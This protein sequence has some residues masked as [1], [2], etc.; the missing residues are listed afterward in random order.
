MRYEQE[1]L[2]DIVEK[3]AE[4][5]EQQ[6][7]EEKDVDLTSHQHERALKGAYRSF[8]MPGKPKTDVDSYFDQAKPYIKALV[9]NQLKEMGS[10]K[11]MLTLWVLWKKPIK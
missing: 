11:I 1:T 9:E 2:K 4:E 7:E 3:E 10:A 6:E 5:E 8:T